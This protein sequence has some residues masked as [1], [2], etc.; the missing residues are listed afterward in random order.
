M[1]IV[2]LQYDKQYCYQVL[3]CSV[4]DSNVIFVHLFLNIE[5]VKHVLVKFLSICVC[6]LPPKYRIQIV[7]NAEPGS[8]VL[9][10]ASESSSV[11]SAVNPFNARLLSNS[12]VT[13]EDHWQDVRLVCLDITNSHIRYE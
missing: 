4:I 1:I 3:F 2:A 12:R 11:P 10:S 9:K 8:H 6:S 5:G 13:A 7:N